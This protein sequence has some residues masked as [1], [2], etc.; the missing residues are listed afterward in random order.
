MVL[1]FHTL[2]ALVIYLL[3]SLGGAMELGLID[4]FHCRV[5]DCSPAPDKYISWLEFSNYLT[6]PTSLHR[7]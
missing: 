2:S 6:I 1:L 4:W 3:V 5:L 7:I